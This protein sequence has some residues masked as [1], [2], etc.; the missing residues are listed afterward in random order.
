M[1]IFSRCRHICSR[2]ICPVHICQRDICPDHI[3]NVDICPVPI[4][5]GRQLSRYTSVQVHIC[6]GY[7]CPV[8]NWNVYIIMKTVQ[9]QLIQLYKIYTKIQNYTSLDFP[10]KAQ[11][12]YLWNNIVGYKSAIFFIILVDKTRA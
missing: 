9:I 3:C 1:L 8:P 12:I 11:F 7:I 10:Q 5:P 4:C 6:P 2:D